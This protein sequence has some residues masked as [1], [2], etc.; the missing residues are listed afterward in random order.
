MKRASIV[1]LGCSFLLISLLTNSLCQN[2]RPGKLFSVGGRPQRVRFMLASHF[3][4]FDQMQE[5]LGPE[6]ASIAKLVSDPIQSLPK[7]PQ[8]KYIRQAKPPAAPGVELDSLAEG[9]NVFAG[10]V[11]NPGLLMCQANLLD[12]VKTAGD[13]N[14]H[15]FRKHSINEINLFARTVPAP[16]GEGTLRVEIGPAAVRR[17]GS[18]LNVLVE[19]RPLELN[20]SLPTLGEL[21]N[22]LAKLE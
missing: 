13:K 9:N 2:E 16:T 17:R 8:G 18:A 15:L 6:T 3:Q 4:T 19:Y 14:T 10:E 11:I 12:L 7:L 22:R 20:C 1:V 21:E 5:I